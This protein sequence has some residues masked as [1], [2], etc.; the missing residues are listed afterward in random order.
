MA[1]RKSF[2]EKK[3]DPKN[4]FLLLQ[5]GRVVRTTNYS[6]SFRKSYIFV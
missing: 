6:V 3:T 2:A 4:I 5:N 1:D